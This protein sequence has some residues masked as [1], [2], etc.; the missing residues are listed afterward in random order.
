MAAGSRDRPPMLATG[1]YPQW[2]QA[3]DA[4]DDSPAIPKHIT[5]ETP[6]NMSPE[7]KAHFEAEKEAIHLILTGIRDEIY[8]IVDAFQTAHEMWEAI[9]RQFRNQRM[10]NVDGARENVGSP[11]KDIVILKLKEKIKSSSADDKERKVE[12]KVEDIETQ[13]LELDHR[14]TKLTA[15]NNHLKQTYKQLFDSIKSSRVQSKE[16]CDDLIN[17]VNLKSVKVADL[18][19]S[20]Q[21]KVLV[22]TTLKEQLKGKALL[23][24]AVSL[25]PIDPALL[26]IC[27]VA[28]TFHEICKPNSKELKQ[29]ILKGPYVMTEFIVP[30]QP[31]TENA[32]AIPAYKVLKTYKNNSLENHVY[33][34]VEAEAIHMVALQTKPTEFQRYKAFNDCTIAYDK[35]EHQF[36]APIAQ[37]MEISIQTCLMPLATKTQNDSFRFV[38]ELKQEMH[39]DLKC[40]ESLEKEIDELESDKAKFSNMYD[41]ILQ[42]CVSNDVK[43]SY[44][45]S[46][47]DLDALDELQCLYLYK[48][49]ECDCVAQKLSKQTESVSKEV[50]NELLKRF[51]KVEKHSISL[52][53]DLQ[54]SGKAVSNTNVLKP[55]MYQI[56]NRS[57]QRRAPQLPQIVRNTNPRMSTST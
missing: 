51:A 13:N 39:A 43:C 18:N 45:L 29:C 11:E 6:M 9:E 57:T 19:A 24:K 37:D 48:V 49:K 2:L 38:H 40:V 3:V 23:S 31:A 21:E 5:V 54:K 17:K 10:V 50:H 27:S 4:T 53:I 36:C 41:V 42:E 8:S 15:E 35:L 47:L 44:L 30:A 52:E 1:R 16:Q 56:N 25:N 7:N 34:D 26:Q 32:P 28:V 22:I 14:V 33:F 46:F 20:L 12:S 55:G